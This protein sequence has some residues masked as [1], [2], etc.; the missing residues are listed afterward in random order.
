MLRFVGAVKARVR[1]VKG[2]LTITA[3][4]IRDVEALRS[5]VTLAVETATSF[6]GA[7]SKCVWFISQI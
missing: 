6:N 1:G 5:D 4:L 2:R 7:M 3:S